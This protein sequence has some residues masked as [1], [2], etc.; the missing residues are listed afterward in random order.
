MSAKSKVLE[1]I[2]K[3]FIPGSV[4]LEDCSFLPG[5]VIVKDTFNEQMLFFYDTDRGC[6]M[7]A[8]PGQ[9]AKIVY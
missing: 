4:A 5:G 8:E 7:C 3:K 6:M 9:A 2:N 1:F